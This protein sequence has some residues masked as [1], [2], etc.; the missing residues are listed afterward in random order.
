MQEFYIN[1][2]ATLPIIK[3]ELINDGRTDFNKFYELI[4]S[5]TTITFTMTNYETGSI[6]IANEPAILIPKESECVEEYYIGYIWKTRD[7]KLN[8]KYKGQFTLTF[9]DGGKLIVPIQ[10]ELIVYIQ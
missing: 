9:S 1:K 7:T 6:K 2:N 3:M 5:G 8:G 10:E 4:Q